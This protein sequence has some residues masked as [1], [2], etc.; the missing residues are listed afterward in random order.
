M[1]AKRIVINPYLDM[2]MVENI[3]RDNGISPQQN[4][5][6]DDDIEEDIQ[7]EF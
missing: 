1:K 6:G 2:E 3:Y 7:E 4:Q 5:G